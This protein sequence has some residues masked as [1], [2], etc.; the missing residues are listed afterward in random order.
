MSDQ[1]PTWQRAAQTLR[2]KQWGDP[3]RV[4]ALAQPASERWRSGAAGQNQL[5]TGLDSHAR[6]RGGERLKRRQQCCRAGAVAIR[7]PVT[8]AEPIALRPGDVAVARPGARRG[9]ELSG[10]QRASPNQGVEKDV[11]AQLAD[12]APV[13]HRSVG[14]GIRQP[15]RLVAVEETVRVQHLTA[16]G[17][18]VAECIVQTLLTAGLQEGASERWTHDVW[19]LE[20]VDED[21]GHVRGHWASTTLRAEGLPVLGGQG[22]DVRGLDADGVTLHQ[23]DVRGVRVIVAGAA[24]DHQCEPLI[25]PCMGELVHDYRPVTDRRRVA[26]HLETLPRG[27]VEADDAT[28]QK[29]LLRLLG[30]DV[31]RDQPKGT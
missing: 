3:V 21:L 19:K 11:E 20:H 22:G 9:V 4:P 27:G 5:R 25:L 31:G 8:N 15:L 17:R 30:I 1:D 29:L 18:V 10:T 26:P 14:G 24:L 6:P 2:A 13:E 7:N 23:R 28:T 12:R 16:R